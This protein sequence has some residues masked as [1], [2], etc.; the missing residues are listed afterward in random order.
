MITEMHYVPN[1]GQTL[2]QQL[3]QYI[4]DTRY[5]ELPDAVV[6]KAKQ[7]ILDTIGCMVAG[8]RDDPVGAKITRYVLKQGIPG[9][10]TIFG[11][12]QLVG[13]EH[14]ALLNGIA[15]HVL[16]LDDVHGP[17]DN[18]QA[19][20]IVPA[21]LAVGQMTAASGTEL[22]LSVVLGLEV[23]SRVGEAVMLPR[24]GSPMHGTGSTGVF[25]SAAVAGKLLGLTTGEI[26][27]ALGI[28][29]DGATGLK[30]YNTPP[31]TGRECKPLH[32]GRAA[33]AGITATL[34]A[35]EG[36]G[37]PLS[38][39]EGP[40]GFCSVMSTQPRPELICAEL[41]ERWAVLESGFKVHVGSGGLASI[42]DAAL[43]LRREHNL[44]PGSIEHV[45]IG[46]TRYRFEPGQERITSRRPST[47]NLARFSAAYL[48]AAALCD[49]EVT[50]RQLTPAKLVDPD[51]AAMEARIEIW[52]DPEVDDAS[53]V[54]TRADRDYIQPASVE[55]KAN[56]QVYRW[57]EINPVG[58]DPKRGLTQEQIEAKFRSLVDGIV[59][60]DSTKRIVDW[61]RSLDEGSDLSSFADLFD[62]DNV[63]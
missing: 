62:Y 25:G 28:A 32:A 61:V 45:R 18:H 33:Q 4:T 48:A 1:A 47:I 35:A 55:V 56:G 31:F 14:A 8:Y 52:N 44:D 19:V 9:P 30:E 46:L 24:Q 34:L 29:G 53:V 58:V 12:K 27:N 41:G 26:A 7:I 21:A 37:G 10:C 5:E 23:M 2:A 63:V 39:M 54:L 59:S 13:A 38:I 51:I 49:G 40:Q 57:L 36:F 22:L 15:A 42:I 17:S 20:V 6:A 60:R 43:G 3:A 11:H 50:P 16:E